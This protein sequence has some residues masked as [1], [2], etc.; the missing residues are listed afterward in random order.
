MLWRVP[1]STPTTAIVV[2]RERAEEDY[3]NPYLSG[4]FWKL[5][6]TDTHMDTQRHTQTHTWTHRGTH[7]YTH[8]DTQTHPQTHTDTQ[9]H[10]LD[11]LHHH[12]KP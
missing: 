4:N 8:M 1:K 12:V 6:G 9:T 2:E 10:T 5:R 11:L 7:R 3:K